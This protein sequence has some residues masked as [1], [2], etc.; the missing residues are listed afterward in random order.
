M[1]NGDKITFD[2]L[3]D[4]G[5]VLPNEK[6]SEDK[7]FKDEPRKKDFTILIL[8]VIAVLFIV[9]C[10]YYSANAYSK[11]SGTIKVSGTS[12]QSQLSSNAKEYKNGKVNINTAGIKVLCTLDGIGET[13]ALTIISYREVNGPFKEIED[14]KNVKDIGEDTFKKIK[15]DI[16]V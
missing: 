6:S 7:I 10:V 5:K 13:R 1:N 16:C 4:S 15:N 11:I 2:E 14:I 12:A 9:G 8:C 3:I